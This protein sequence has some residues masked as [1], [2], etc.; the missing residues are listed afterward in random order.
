M[1]S[2][3]PLVSILVPIYGVEKFIERCAISLFG[4]SFDS[5]E[6]VFVNDCT[7][8]N[9]MIILERVIANYPHRKGQVKVVHH[10]I[11]RGLAAAR[12]TAV[13]NAIG[14]YILH[15]DSDDYLELDAV[16]LLYEKA[17][18][19]NADIVVCD[20]H[21]IWEKTSRPLLINIGES[22]IDLI[23]LILSAEVMMG[24][25]NKLIKRKLYK[26]NRIEAQAGVNLGEDLMIIPK[27]MYFAAIVSK[28]DLCLYYYTQT[29]S[30]SYTTQKLSKEH[31]DSLIFVMNDLTSFFMQKPDGDLYVKPL[32]RG[33]VVKK[34]HM[35]FFADREFL[36]QL[37]S[38][39]PETNDVTDHS[40]L[41]RRDKISHSL[42]RKKNI[43][44]FIFYRN[45]YKVCFE[46]KSLINRCIGFN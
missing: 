25:V 24:V 28:L 30:N 8:D 41:S 43:N 20:F 26:D 36:L 7:L 31:I 27:L 37:L 19:E 22:K 45:V 18:K 21:L 23:G 1:N 10:T 44:G 15:V 29:N 38:V 5:I 2:S 40:F 17:I 9:S 12:N 35:L 16:E 11:N 46:I 33:K 39:F 34:M 3:S 32:L 42:L 6:F 14:D 4:Q 13:S